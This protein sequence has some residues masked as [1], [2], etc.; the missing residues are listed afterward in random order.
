MARTLF[1]ELIGVE[2]DGV[3]IVPAASYGINLAAAN[4]PVRTGQRIVVLAEQ[5][6][7]NVYPW[8]DLA[9]RSGGE[10][11]TVHGRRTTTGRQR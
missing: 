4:L 7:A 3:A 1:G 10:V 11:L 9:E 2:A 6:P 8:R 5:F